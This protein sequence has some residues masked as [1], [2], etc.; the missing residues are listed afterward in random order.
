[1]PI[2]KTIP[3]RDTVTSDIARD[4]ATAGAN[5]GWRKIADSEAQISERI[6]EVHRRVRAAS[7][8]VDKMATRL[9]EE[10]DEAP[11]SARDSRWQSVDELKEF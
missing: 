11:M 4:S 2:A 9:Q 1:M 10:Q 7:E 6:A 8:K 5:D 3:F